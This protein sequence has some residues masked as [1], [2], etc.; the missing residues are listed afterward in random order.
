VRTPRPARA[1]S[2]LERERERRRHAGV[3]RP[4]LYG[5]PVP[6]PQSV[7]TLMFAPAE[8]IDAVVDMN[9]PGVWIFGA[10]KDADR[11][12]GLGVVVEQARQDFG[13]MSLVKYA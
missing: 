1:V 5:N 7:N 8:R 3:A 4:Q 6:S 13:F 10:V 11:A 12:M 9:H 2:S